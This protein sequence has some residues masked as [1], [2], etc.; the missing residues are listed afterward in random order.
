M[1]LKS[2]TVE[3]FRQFYGR[4]SVAFADH[5]E[6]NVTVVYGPNGGGKT[7]LLNAFTWALYKETS[8]A[9]EQ[10]EDLVNNRAWAEADVGNEVTAR[11]IV[12][13]EH[14]GQQ[15]TVERFTKDRKAP[16]GSRLRIQ[17]AH[18]EV[19]FVDEG[20]RSYDRT[21]TAEG[22]I[23]QILPERLHRF[24]F[25]DGERIEQLVKPDS[26]AEI[27]DAIKTILGLKTTE[28]AIGH[29]DDARKALEKE[30]SQVGGDEV[31]R[32][33]EELETVRGERSRHMESK[34][35]ATDNRAGRQTQLDTVNARL[36]Q[37]DDAADLQR[38]REELEDLQETT[39]REIDARHESLA[40]KLSERGYLAFV[41][42]LAKD[43][44]AT[45]EELRTKGEIPTPL[46]RQFVD[47]LLQKGQCICG[48]VLHEGED[49]YSRVAEWRQ[50]AGREDVETAWTQLSASAT[51]FVS[52]REQLFH[53][54]HETRGELAGLQDQ[55]AKTKEKLSQIKD[56]MSHL[57][58]QEIRE[59]EARRNELTREI[60]DDS[61]SIKVAERD[62]DA[63]DSR[64]D[65]LERDL[66]EA[67]Q[68]IDKARIAQRRVVVAREARD[69]CATVLGLRTEEV[70]NKIDGRV[71]EVYNRISF[72]PYEP[73][74]DSQFRLRLR[75][76]VGGDEIS[77]AKSTGESQILS[78]AFVGATAEHAQER[79]NRQA[80]AGADMASEGGVYPMVMDSPFGSL[81]ENYQR[82]IAEAVPK[83]APQVILFVSKSQ[84]LNAV[85]EVLLPHIDSEYVI[86]FH[87]PKPDQERE[88]ITLRA[89]TAPYI[90]PE[91]GEFEW[92]EVKEVS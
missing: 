55:N 31:K 9:F 50:K 65:D 15:Y 3:N 11:V 38:R 47:D 54:I 22:T 33:A 34:K 29:L 6:R 67:G 88:T 28:R 40:A 56:S 61:L 39:M 35:Q 21:D 83:L 90:E 77:V 49:P 63:L 23:N 37:L 26:Y 52:E 73:V 18:V 72:K 86:E 82:E 32:V 68:A 36:A 48:G 17:D 80:G 71:R 76:H 4:Q 87:T 51:H 24:F 78:L 27:E 43:A 62:I 20:G 13:F 79:Q 81:D 84:G 75:T 58:S 89:G 8:P 14:N 46:K 45:F 64:I 57:D 25:F 30:Y 10:P 41:G 5:H 92:A 59:L 16:D 70:R 85:Q 44:S 74:L 60:A 19:N 42:G 91:K 12:V 66:E 7:A 2:L 69:F 1:I 53:Y